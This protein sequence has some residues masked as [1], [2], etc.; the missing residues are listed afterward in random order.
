LLRATNRIKTLEIPR[1]IFNS[2]IQNLQENGLQDKE[3]IAFWTGT[4]NDTTA[5]IKNVIFADSY[6]EFENQEL[7]AR[8]P[9]MASFKIGESIHQRN[10]KLFVQIHSHPFEA[11]HSFVDNKYPISHKIGF[12]SIVVPYFGKNV[13]DLS[14]CKVYE[15]LGN[16]KWKELSQKE[17]S[18]RFVIGEDA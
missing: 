17:V 1:S 4:L 15:Y 9:L 14:Q 13:I 18:R 5:Q 8:V 3:G 16:G 10:E 11:F 7:F 2:T 12:L 6:P